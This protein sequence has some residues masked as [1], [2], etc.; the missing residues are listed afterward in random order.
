MA[1]KKMIISKNNPD[2]R[3]KIK[4][5]MVTSE[6]C[7]KCNNKCKKGEQYLVFLKIKGVGKGVFCTNA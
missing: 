7:E 5:K 6:N 4:G 1:T 2:N 3:V